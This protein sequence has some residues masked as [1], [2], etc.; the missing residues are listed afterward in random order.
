MIST[1]RERMTSAER[2]KA[3]LSGE[4]PDRVP[5]IP[6]AYG[7][8]ALIA[9]FEIRDCYA[10]PEKS[11]RAQVLCKEI[12]KHDG[13]P[14]FSYASFGAWEFGGEIR[15]PS[16]EWDQAPVV[17]RTAVS[18]PEDV[19]NLQVPPVETSGYLPNEIR[20]LKCVAA[21]GLPLFVKLGTPFTTAGTIIGEELMLRWMIKRPELVHTVLEKVTDFYV[22]IARYFVKEYGAERII[23]FEGAPSE[24]SDL[25]SP[26]QFEEFAL[27]YLL[28]THQKILALGV[29]KFLT[30]VC[31]EQNLNLVHWR[32]VPMGDGGTMS[33]G[34]EVDLSKAIEIF[35]ADTIIAGNLDTKIIQ[36]GSPEEIYEHTK[37]TILTGK[38]APRGYI[39][40]PGCE[41]PP[42]TPF[43]NVYYMRKAL[44]DHGFYD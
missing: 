42:R 36:M 11:F 13:N 8:A 37:E 3:V 10:D 23:A 4:K 19:E 41:L 9:G 16:S 35:G 26:G 5:F 25:I 44:N 39:L 15:F 31:G 7:F 12:L 28:K 27:P 14:L 20:F 17:T 2:M 29:P 43:V 32:K 1:E 24:A 38:R 21:E 30:H 34:H 40:M 22:D 18:S 33:F 6:F